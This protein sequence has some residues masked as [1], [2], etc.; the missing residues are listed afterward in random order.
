MFGVFQQGKSYRQLWRRSSTRTPPLGRG[1]ASLV[2]GSDLT[3]ELATLKPNNGIEVL[4][5]GD[6]NDARALFARGEIRFN[7]APP[8]GY[9]WAFAFTVGGFTRTLNV[10]HTTH[11]ALNYPLTIPLDDVAE[12]IDGLG[13][14]SIAFS[15]LFVEDPAN[16]GGNV[17][18]EVTLPSVYVDQ[19]RAPESLVNDLFIANRVPA[20]EQVSVPNN[21][22]TIS[23][24]LH[25]ASG[26]GV[27]LTNTTVTIDGD[28]AYSAGAFVGA[29]TGT[30]TS[31]V[32]PTVQDVLFEITIPSVLLPLGSEQQVLVVVESELSGGASPIV[33]SY[34]FTAS[35]T[36]AP[37][38]KSAVMLNKTTLRV[39]FTDDVLLD[40]TSRGALN[41]ANYMV[42]RE[43]APAVSL[44][45]VSAA[46]V[47]GSTRSV[48]ITFDIEASPGAAYTLFAKE[49]VDDGGNVIGVA[50]RQIAFTGYVPPRPLGRRFELLDFIP[51][52]NIAQDLTAAQGGD[53]TA[54]GTGDLRKFILCLQDVVDV[55]L[56]YVDRWTEIIDV[57]LAPEKFLD[58][59][60][61]DLGNPFSACI[62]DLT[63]NE[64]RRLARILI[65]IYKQKGTERGVINAVRFFTGVEVTLDIINARQFWQLDISLLDVDTLLAPP[66][67]SPLWYS[68]FIVSPVTLTA[69]QRERILCLATYMKPAHEHIL[70]IIEPGDQ[71]TPSGYWI[72]NVSLLGA[73]P[74]VDPSTILA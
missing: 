74:S 69:E 40:A 11:G 73:D 25:D 33:E 24:V 63:L 14:I 6:V 53:P 71:I 66:V 21:L 56:C 49:L 54:P 29:W 60:L 65:T 23:F 38:L 26:T 18:V 57:D 13:T 16:P 67:G 28:V 51:R 43:S 8:E 37:A 36:I 15:L 7:A 20:P 48:D 47:Q 62:A 2:L 50:G 17:P 35:D 72:L 45:V 27:D 64:K 55:L 19:I 70:G 10:T 1:A 58:A 59:I 30:V 61:Q 22:S 42:V 34:T 52:F 46:A 32:G 5:S 12:N 3:D 41:A 4:T 68:F 39:T 31:S 9:G 44:N